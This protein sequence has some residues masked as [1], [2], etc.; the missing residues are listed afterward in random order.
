DDKFLTGFFP[1]YPILIKLVHV[2]VRSYLISG[3][4]ITW[5]ALWGAIYFYVSIVKEYYSRI[6]TKI[7]D[8]LTLI[9]SALYFV[10]FPSGIYL[11][12]VYTESLYALFALAAIN[13]AYKK[14]LILT[15]LLTILATAAHITGFFL[16][17]IV[18][19]MLFEEKVSKIK[20]LAV[21]AIGSIGIIA[22]SIYLWIKFNNPFEFVHSQTV[23]H[24]LKNK[25]WYSYDSISILDL[26]LLIS[27]ITTVIYWYKRKRSFSFYTLLFIAIPL[28]GGQFDGFARYNLMAFPMQLMFFDYLKNKIESQFISLMILSS[29][30]TYS[31]IL[32]AAGFVTH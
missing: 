24:W 15:A 4:I 19:L 11:L 21:G 12:C 30:W 10:L 9:K 2:I 13:F 16:I 23:H 14:K 27:L 28:I 3:L 32:F 18:V 6:N 17:P 1:L 5:L 26:F 25:I 31:V 22:Y 20:S 8:N 7:K 29:L